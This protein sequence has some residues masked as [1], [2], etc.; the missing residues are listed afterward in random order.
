MSRRWDAGS[1]DRISDPMVR[2]GADVLAR[3][4]LEGG[5]TVI[6]AGCGTGRV[7]EQ[8]MER[9]PRG[10][11]IA[12]DVSPAMLAEARVRLARFG[13]RVT[14][15]EADLNL[16]LPV[17]GPAD[18]LL[19]TATLHWVLDQEALFGHLAAALRPGG[20]LVA[21]CG[22]EGNNARVFAALESL[23]ERP[24]DRL[25][26]ADPARARARLERAGFLDI[27][28]WLTP[29]PVRFD[30]PEAIETYL[31]TVFLGP[32][33]DRPPDELPALAHA[34]AARLPEPVLDYV[35]LNL[36]AR[37]G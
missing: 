3:M 12:L 27:E 30:T 18:A 6:D 11:V 24:M 1:Y 20:R 26:F 22:G 7:T 28:A 8:L 10:R 33:T 34:V 14:L 9:L 13:D 37:R 15:L 36:V 4:D 32:L 25:R 23:G 35:R 5:E 21:Q 19:S 29:E 2:M 16:P 31:A 17:P